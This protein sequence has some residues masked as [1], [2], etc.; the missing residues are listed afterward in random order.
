MNRDPA[1]CRALHFPVPEDWASHGFDDSAWHQAS[2][3]RAR[4]VTN[5]RAYRDY[6]DRFERADFIWSHNLDQDNLVLCRLQVP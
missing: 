4:A 2:T 6:R 3:Y 1:S 5:Q